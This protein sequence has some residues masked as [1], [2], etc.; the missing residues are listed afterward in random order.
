MMKMRHPLFTL[1]ILSMMTVSFGDKVKNIY[2]WKFP[3]FEWLSKKQEEDAI[4]S[5][6]Y[7]PSSCVFED[8]N[9][10]E[11]GR[12]FITITNINTRA[13]PVSLTTVTNKTGLGGPILRPYPDWSWY[14]NSY[15]C[16][17]IINVYRIDIQCNHLF[18]LDA[19]KFGT[20]QICNPKLLIFNLKDDTLV[21]TIYIPIDIA[22][23]KTG[24][25]LLIMPLVY[26]PN[27]KC[28]QFLDEMIVFMAD[29]EG[30][31][32]VVY[33]SFTK[34]MCRIESDY[35][36]PT[37]TSFSIAGKNFTYVGGIFSMTI[38]DDDLY[39]AAVSGNK[40]YKIKIKYLLKCPNEK[41]AN[42]QTRLVKK[43]SSQTIDLTSAGQ[44]IFYS[45]FRAM[46]ILRTNVHTIC[47]LNKTEILAQDSEKF[48]SVSSMKISSNECQLKCISDRF[49][50]Y[51]TFN[52]NEINFRY[53]K[54][55]LC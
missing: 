43:L 22:T 18:V 6:I 10:A 41:E 44:S 3:D 2:T 12:L 52:T 11:D 15:M 53:F 54:I 19:G 34:S 17:G 1:L 36:K 14:N 31:G 37:D 27:G 30:Y 21:K 26:I 35:M 23:N 39:F 20:D 32:L 49:Q 4:R 25:G 13:S 7:N 29:S 5:N 33:N 45:D 55:D 51:P 24:S 40:I 9:E 38:I 46:S 47:N 28:T 50:H 42:K 16:D 48:Q 8:A